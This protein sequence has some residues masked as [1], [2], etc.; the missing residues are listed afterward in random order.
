MHKYANV[1]LIALAA[2]LALSSGAAGAE[3][4]DVVLNLSEAVRIT[5]ENNAVVKAA[6]ENLKGAV[7]ASG[8]AKAD[9]L[10]KISANYAYTYLA[11][12][13][14]L[15]V[16]GMPPAVQIAH[17]DQYH[18]D[19]T[20][21]QPLFSG[22][23]LS[24]RH[25]IAKL[26]VKTKEKE[27]KQA[28]LDVTKGV[29]SAYYNVLLTQK[30]LSVANET[31]E[32]LRS[33][34]RDNQ[35][36][37]DR[38]VIRLNDLL[39]SRVA[40]SNAIQ[41]RERAQAAVQ[42]SLS[43]LNRWLAFDI[44]RNTRIED[45]ETITPKVYHLDELIQTGMQNRPLLQVLQLSLETLENVT[46]LEKSGYYPQVAL[47]GGYG[48][49]GD[50]PQASNNN[51]SNEHNAWVAVQAKWTF[52]DS[53]KTK[54]KVSKAKADKGAFLQTIR[55]A[56]DGI[57]LEIKKAFLDLEVAEKNI[58]TA[59]A[60]L[61]Q[62]EENLRITQ[63]GYRQQAATSTEVLDARTDLTRAQTYYYVALYGYLEGVAA[64]ERATGLGQTLSG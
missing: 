13:P 63:L 62:A 47:I 3:P 54:S 27:K 59:K 60:S 23:A 31:I 14:Y 1:L 22:F 33:H 35:R 42:M 24:T 45:I 51:Y 61:T 9:R 40:L 17:A 26:G 36:F 58:E 44:N 15:Q 10:P 2:G 49:D 53:F 52:F 38:G 30:L 64:L 39:R 20:M 19:L 18:W 41:N 32:S 6:T 43:D 8:S 21:I 4:Q 12:A 46:Q 55:S 48:Q 16:N 11:D 56:E 50:N 57:R 28:I 25:E 34:E 5:V 29:K 7:Y 37:Y